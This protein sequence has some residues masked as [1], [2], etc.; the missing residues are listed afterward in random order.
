MGG[1]ASV[2]MMYTSKQRP[3]VT[4]GKKYEIAQSVRKDNMDPIAVARQAQQ[5]FGWLDFALFVLMLLI[6]TLIGIY[7]GFWGKKADTPEEYL[8]GG[9]SMSVLPVSMSL[10]VS[11]LSGIV[12][13][14]APT[15]IYQFGTLYWLICVALVIV[16]LAT[17]YLY[18]PV[19]Y[20][21]RLT[22]TY[23]GG[24]KAVVWTDMLQGIVVLASS[25]AIVVLG[26]NQLGGIEAVWSRNY[27]G[28]RIR[29]F[30][31]NPSPFERMTFWIA[32]IGNTFFMFGSVTLNQAMI[33]RYLSLPT[34]GKARTTMSSSL[35]SLGA[36]VYEDL[37]R[38]FMR[39]DISDKRVNNII[40]CIISL[41]GVICVLIVFV[42]DKLGNVLEGALIGSIVSMLFMGWVV[43]GT[44]IARANGQLKLNKLNTSIA[45]CPVN[46][47]SDFNFTSSFSTTELPLT[48]QQPE[49]AFILYRISYVYYTLLG[50]IVMLIVGTIVSHFTNAPDLE[51]TNPL[52]FA[53]MVRNSRRQKYHRDACDVA[54]AGK[55]YTSHFPINPLQVIPVRTLPGISLGT[56]HC[57]RCY[58]QETLA[59]VLGFCR[60]GELLRIDRHNKI[61]SMIANEL[62]RT[63]KYE[64]YEE[65][66]C[67]S[68]DGSTGRADIIIID[69][70]KIVDSFSI[71]QSVL[72][73]ARN[74]PTVRFENSE[75]QS[76]EVYK[77]RRAIYL[78]CCSDL[79]TKY[80][81]KT[82]D[83]IGIMIGA[84]G[85]YPT[86]VLRS[87]PKIK[88]S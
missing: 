12:M 80:N 71:P 23:E 40:K 64:V 74:N 1:I 65:I 15:E 32:I 2:V 72:R 24:I 52:L 11:F 86:G 88:S 60:K 50:M 6:S 73:T 29:F 33:Q 3:R 21:L 31:F 48:S 43:F 18:L 57:R 61:R 56:I 36:T 26:L 49:E 17:Y 51:K 68:A 66:G 8:H 13:M 9:K 44:Q 84:R 20:E 4:L 28:G 87:L 42:V 85:T 79:G 63:D 7:F 41:I 53:P 46:D 35:N 10:I 37:V 83:V 27:E 62:R 14:G 76:R 81:I 19:F 58:E 30:E 47:A 45:G 54:G 59:H 78:P 70:K 22:S 34:Y 69:R 75:E 25:L 16:G 39:K 82:W 67:L 77:E 38:P 55:K 5:F